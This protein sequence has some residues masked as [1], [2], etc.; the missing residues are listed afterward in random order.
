MKNFNEVKS[1]L[2][3]LIDNCFKI[4]SLLILIITFL[5]FNFAYTLQSKKC[6]VK[7]SFASNQILTNYAKVK[8]NCLFFKS[9]EITNTQFNNI[10]FEIPESYFVTVLSQ[11]SPNVLKVKYANIIGFVNPSYLTM[12][13]LT[14]KQPTLEGITFNINEDAGTHIRKTPD[15]SS[16]ENILTTIPENTKN[17]KY[18]A[19]I[20]ATVPTGGLSEVWYYAEYTPQTSPTTVYTGYIYS[21]RTNNLTNIPTNLE[22]DVVINQNNTSSSVNDDFITINPTLKI[23]LIVLICLPVLIIF[24]TLLFKHTKNKKNNDISTKEKYQL[25]NSAN[26]NDSKNKQLNHNFIGNAYSQPQENSTNQI[27]QRKTIK[28]FKDKQFTRADNFKTAIETISSKTIS[29]G[30]KNVVNLDMLD[31]EDDDLL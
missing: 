29:S 18:I 8:S 1:K 17:I 24:L 5:S 2:N 12:V 23:I 21:E 16:P 25:E 9:E 13:N 14:P 3:L 10:Y 26:F 19:K 31:E 7:F 11:I 15:A 27:K 6:N 30:K 20:F 22:D 28:A 4:L